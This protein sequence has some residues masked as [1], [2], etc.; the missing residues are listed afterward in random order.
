VQAFRQVITLATTVEEW[1]QAIERALAA[2][3]NS[4]PR[5]MARQAVAREHDWD[6]LVLRIARTIAERLHIDSHF[7][8]GG[9]YE[10]SQQLSQSRRAV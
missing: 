2:E 6:T 3:E 9:D 4:P 5:R 1:S 8:A 7:T 10:F